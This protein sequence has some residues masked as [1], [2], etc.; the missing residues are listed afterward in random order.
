M[1]KSCNATTCSTVLSVLVDLSKERRLHDCIRGAIPN[2]IGLLESLDRGI[3]SAT[4]KVLGQLAKEEY[5][6]GTIGNAIPQLVQRLEHSDS[7]VREAVVRTM[8]ELAKNEDSHSSVREAVVNTMGELAKN[9]DFDINGNVISQLIQRFEDSE[10]TV[11]DAVINSLKTLVKIDRLSQD[12]YPLLFNSL[13]GKTS[14]VR[15]AA[16]EVLSVGLPLGNI[17]SNAPP[18]QLSS[19]LGRLVHDKDHRVVV[20]ATSIFIYLANTGQI[21]ELIVPIIQD[22]VLALTSRDSSERKRGAYISLE[23]LKHA[24]LRNLLLPMM[25]WHRCVTL[26]EPQ[27]SPRDIVIVWEKLS[28]FGIFKRWDDSDFV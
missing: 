3:C 12:I 9:A 7:S 6:C 13:Q 19:V 25:A 26:I 14:Q 28:E 5:L 2:V 16:A 20:P 11:Y 15:A 10:S 21:P 4:V 18:I 22:T 17:H 8:W 1:V 23:L 27:I 24:S